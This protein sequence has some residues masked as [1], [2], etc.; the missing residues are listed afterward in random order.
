MGADLYIKELYDK[1]GK[2][3][4][5]FEVSEEAVNSGYFRDC[6]NPSGLF[7]NIGMSWWQTA[8]K[9]KTS[10]N[11]GKM[12]PEQ[13]KEFK[14]EITQAFKKSK[15]KNR[16]AYKEWYNLLIRF[17]DIAINKNYNIKFSV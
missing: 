12:T 10:E 9:Y 7:W 17:L 5:A 1:K 15:V 3:I 4:G 2:K 13:A 6:Y 8:N 14:D 16:K 11:D